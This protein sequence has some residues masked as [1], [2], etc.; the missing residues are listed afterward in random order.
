MDNL[1]HS[2]QYPPAT[3][4]LYDPSNEHDACGLGFI[5][6]IKGK[7]SHSIITQ[8]LEILKNLT[9]RG[10]TGADPLLGDGA[11]IL[12]QLP[13][14]F[15]RRVCGKLAI[16]LP[17]AGQYGVGMICLPKEPASRMA[18]EQEIER[19]IASEGQALLGW[20]DVPTN[21]TGLSK[22]AIAL[23][24]VIRMVFVGRGDKTLDTDALERKLYVIR[25]KAGHAIRALNL[26]HGKEFYVPSMST[27]TLVY[28]GMLL[29]NQVGEYFLDLQESSMVSA[30]AMVHQRFSTNTFPTWDLAHPFRF[31]CHNG[32]INTLRG[33]FNWM[34]AREGAI[35]STVLGDDLQKL[36]PLIYDGQSD[37][38]AFDNCL[39]LLIMGGYTPAHAMMLMIPEAWAGNSLM[40]EDRRAF[41]EYHAALMEPWDGPAAMA[42]TD[43]RQIGATLDR[44]GLRPA[45]YIVTDDDF[46][47][48]SSESGVLDIPEHKIIRKWRLQPGKMLLVDLEE[49]RIVDD[50]ELKRTLSTA[51]PYREWIDRCRIS[52][53]A[54]P[55]PAPAMPSEVPLLDRQQAF[56]YTQEDL[57]IIL[58]PMAQNGEEA[59]GSM[60]NDAALPVLSRRAKVFYNYFKQLFAQVTNPPIDPIREELVMSLTSFIGPRPNLLGIGETDPPMRLEVEQPVLTAENMEKLRHIELFTSGA[61][62]ARELDI[63]Y[64]AAWGAKGMEAALASLAAHAVDAIKMGYN[65]LILSDRGVASDFLP[66]PA[67]LA[68]AAVHEHLVQK[69]M[70]TRTGLVV[71]T[72]TAREVHHFALLAGY[73]AEAIHPYLALETLSSLNELIPEVNPEQSTKRFIKAICKGLNK[74]MSKMG[75]STYQSYCGAQIFEAVGLQKAF[76]DKYFTGTASNVEG[77]GLFEVAE[78]SARLHSLAFGGDPV[79]EHALDAGGEYAYRVRG[80]E[81]MWTPESISRLQHSARS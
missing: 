52:V 22:G 16:T 47:V 24:P 2:S 62:R 12:I 70:R 15:L 5:A 58:A 46:I 33:N 23:E 51:K 29:A 21:N 10:A 60:G 54:L 37:S 13:D 65:I 50:E 44:N 76:V 7:K 6:H 48:M 43:G 3:Q 66:I 59:T 20:R 71:E 69:G 45:R 38:A 4:G 34:R 30:L 8:G 9:H 64:P 14:A 49:G 55:E 57:K 26:V 27:R 18:C 39:E 19:A 42:F 67:L 80:E 53:E 79:L 25:K 28:K 56:G 61:F 1:Q 78:E 31:I 77:I 32:E 17:A 41:Y 11:G 72:G 75:I 36:W 73:G 63:C 81:H 74:V 40:D 68:T 35:A